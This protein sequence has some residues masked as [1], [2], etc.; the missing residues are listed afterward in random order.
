MLFRSHSEP[1]SFPASKQAQDRWQA[2][3]QGVNCRRLGGE[4]GKRPC[5]APPQSAY[6]RNEAERNEAGGD[7]AA[8]ASRGSRVY[9]EFSGSTGFPTSWQQDAQQ[10]ADTQ[11][12]DDTQQHADTQHHARSP[13]PSMSRN[14]RIPAVPPLG[15]GGGS[16]SA[17]QASISTSASSD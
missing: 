7:G 12:D 6:E 3:V 10:H 14:L 2:M 11:Q 5:A 4:N 16:Y 17:V 9:P 13:T 1:V 8:G 15:G